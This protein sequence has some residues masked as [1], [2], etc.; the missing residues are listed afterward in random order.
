MAPWLLPREREPDD[1]GE[2]RGM[3]DDGID[4]GDCED[5]CEGW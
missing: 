3:C 4:D 1:D 5:E 2:E